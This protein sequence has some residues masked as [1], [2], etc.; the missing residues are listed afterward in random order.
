VV[1]VGSD[2][3]ELAVK[4][5]AAADIETAAREGALLVALARPDVRY[6]VQT[7]VP[8]TTGALFAHTA[9]GALVVTQWHQAEKKQYTAIDAVEW[10]VLGSELAALHVRLDD[11]TGALSRASEIVIDLDAERAAIDASR[12]RAAAKDPT[13]AHEIGRYLDA[14]RSLL[15]VWGARG[16]RTPPVPERPI[17]ND[18]NQHNGCDR[19]DR[20]TGRFSL[21]R[22]LGR[23]GLS[24]SGKRPGLPRS[25]ARY[26]HPSSP[27]KR[28]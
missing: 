7:L 20:R 28:R 25:S 21:C 5:F 8:T 1:H 9:D 26:R 22:T 6:R 19:L 16:L 2:A 3:G 17:H 12:N 24:R 13:R 15:D 23:A 4:V 14:R 10:R 18:Y 27:R 11:F